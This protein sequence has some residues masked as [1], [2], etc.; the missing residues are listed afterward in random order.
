VYRREGNPSSERKRGLDGH[1][2]KGH[3]FYH[4]FS[5]IFALDDRIFPSS[6]PL[7][8]VQKHASRIGV[9]KIGRLPGHF[10]GFSDK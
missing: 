10:A 3:S 5:P 7:W 4:H 6:L 8:K 2:V 9:P 1:S